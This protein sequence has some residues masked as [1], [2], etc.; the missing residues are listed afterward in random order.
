MFKV[1]WFGPKLNALWKKFS[2]C[3]IFS[4]CV[5]TMPCVKFKFSKYISAII[6]PSEKG[7]APHLNKHDI[8]SPRM[9][10]Y[11]VWLKMAQWFWRRWIYEKCMTVPTTTDNNDGEISIRKAHLKLYLMWTKPSSKLSDSPDEKNIQ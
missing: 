7:L 5:A 1:R 4:K 11:Q 6:S 2:K 9:Y 10:F 8:P 3:V